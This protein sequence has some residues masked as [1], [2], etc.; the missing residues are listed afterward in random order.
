MASSIDDVLDLSKPIKR[1]KI[2]VKTRPISEFYP[3]GGCICITN[4]TTEIK[5]IGHTIHVPVEIYDKLNKKQKTS[6]G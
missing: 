1:L 6:R 2:P 5:R 4:A 3:K